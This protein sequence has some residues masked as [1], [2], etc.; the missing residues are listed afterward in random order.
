MA[1]TDKRNRVALENDG[2][3][4]D[5][6]AKVTGTAKY[7][8]DVSL[9]NMMWARL[10]RSPFAEATLTSC[11]LAAARKIKGVL[12]VQF[13]KGAEKDEV[14][15]TPAEVRKGEY[16]G[17][18]VGHI[19]AENI[20]LIDDAMSALK[21]KWEHGEPKT[22]LRRLAGPTVP[23][24]TKEDLK[25]QWAKLQSEVFPK[26]A[27][28]VEQT[29]ETQVQHHA[30]LE[31]HGGIVN[32]KG[33]TAEVF[34]ST[35]GTFSYRD[36]L[37]RS[38]GLDKKDIEVHCEFVGGGFGGK[39]GGPGVEGMLAG[40]MSKQF[41]RPCKVMNTRKHENTDTGMRPAS[42]QYYKLAMDD[43]GKILGG[44]FHSWGGVGVRR[45][46]GGV[47]AVGYDLGTVVRTH[48]DIPM[49]ATPPRPQRAP[50]WPQGN[51]AMEVFLDE[52]AAAAGMDPIE[53]RKL[54][55]SNKVRQRQ[56]D[57]AKAE[58]EW[59]KRKADGQWPGPIKRGFGI[60]SAEWHN[61]G[62]YPSATEVR[63]YRD[64]KVEAISGAQDIGTGTKTFFVDLIASRLGLSREYI[65]AR[66]G[67]SKYPQAPASGGSWLSRSLSLSA[68]NAGDQAK[69][70]LLE[71][72][73]KQAGAPADSLAIKGREIV[74][75]ADGSKVMSWEEACK[76]IAEEH[77]SVVASK[78]EKY[79]GTGDSEGVCAVQAD[80]DT[81]TG[82]IKLV[83]VVTIQACGVPVNRKTVESQIIGGT[84]QGISFAMFEERILNAVN[85]AHVNPNMESYKIA[86]PADMPEIVPIIDVPE[87]V[88]GIRAAGEPPIVGVPGAIANAVANAIGARMRSLP[89][90]PSKVLAAL[91]SK[92]GTA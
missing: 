91:S 57:I 12:D 39:L 33:T 63:I 83:K 25:T 69:A 28:V 22:N 82:V 10:I 43:K 13:Y 67:S 89:L 26:A 7:T 68:M 84:I 48:E 92:G 4:V 27:H 77:L 29:Y 32:H 66:L 85:G 19:C 5:A 73:A 53:F 31:V 40:K 64:G 50:G 86:G 59:S 56:Y 58:I 16:Q 18:P 21:L 1:T 3:R 17:V 36:G 78:D 15:E 54:N 60:A 75:A 44:R 14:T 76:L 45:G 35:Q 90:T 62:S 88:T 6:R 34:A 20:H 38:I 81:E 41:N 87:G 79:F 51:F 72:V 65:T 70:R 49:S 80:V 47:S 37:E 24:P 52:C 74:K 9:P 71:L 2:S 55:D 23:E 30:A 8:H 11:D 46:G 42:R 61:E